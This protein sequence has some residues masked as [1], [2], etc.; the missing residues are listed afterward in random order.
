MNERSCES[1]NEEATEFPSH[2]TPGS[3][4]E[5]DIIVIETEVMMT[6]SRQPQLGIESLMTNLVVDVEYKRESRNE[7]TKI[8]PRIPKPLNAELVSK[9]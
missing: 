7:R 6:I 1:R 3:F 9:L 8:P 5:R 2:R 4:R